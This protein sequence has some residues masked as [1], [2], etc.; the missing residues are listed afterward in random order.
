MSLT[1]LCFYRHLVMENMLPV[2]LTSL[3]PDLVCKRGNTFG[4]GIP[5]IGPLLDGGHSRD[6]PGWI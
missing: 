1:E 2:I 4:T 5:N 6:I 3:W